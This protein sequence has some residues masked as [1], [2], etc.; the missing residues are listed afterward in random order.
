MKADALLFT[1]ADFTGVRAYEMASGSVCV[2]TRRAPE[3]LSDNED[4]LA[5]LEC[6]DGT[7]VF[8]VADGMGGLP[9][10]DQASAITVRQLEKSVNNSCTDNAELRGAILD[11]IEQANRKVLEK[12]SGSGTTIAA[13]ELA[14]HCVRAYH[15]GDSAILV[16]GQRGK[17]KYQT[18]PHSPVGYAVEAGIIEEEDALFHEDRHLISNMIGSKAMRLEIGPRIKLAPRDTLIIGS[19]GLFDNMQ[20]EEIVEVIRSGPLL[21][22]AENLVEI[23]SARML[24]PEKDTPHKPDDLGLILYRRQKNRAVL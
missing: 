12:T 5:L 21:Q 3:K 15:V 10:G 11:G 16:V 9:S 17:V 24:Q 22:A 8:A 14:D 23:C 1:A 4:S 20:I 6:S 7:A 18:I 13:V 19:D 2:F